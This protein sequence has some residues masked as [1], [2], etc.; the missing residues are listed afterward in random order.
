MP[1]LDPPAVACAALLSFLIGGVYYGL[2][3][4]RLA[5]L[6]DATRELPPWQLAAVELVRGLVL[7]TVVAGLV[8]GLE[9][10]TWYA[11]ALLGLALWIGFPAVLWSGAMVHERTPWRLAALHAGDWLVKLP[12]VAGLL[13]AWPW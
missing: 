4:A 5:A 9:L 2:L 6:T 13:G 7:S 3:G 1:D 10:T 12:A 8:G 11:G